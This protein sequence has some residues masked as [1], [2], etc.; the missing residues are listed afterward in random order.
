VAA[1]ASGGH[2]HEGPNSLRLGYLAAHRG[3]VAAGGRACV[4]AILKVGLH[5]RFATATIV[6]SCTALPGARRTGS[7]PSSRRYLRSR[8]RTCSVS[9]SLLAVEFPWTR[10]VSRSPRT[11]RRRPSRRPNFAHSDS[12]ILPTRTVRLSVSHTSIGQVMSSACGFG[13]DSAAP[14]R[15]GRG[16]AITRRYMGSGSCKKRGM[17]GPS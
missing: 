8:S 9:A 5:S 1:Q 12:L 14:T 10:E 7:P 6:L 16:A 11:P 15:F 3:T 17:T 4:P 2:N 13:F